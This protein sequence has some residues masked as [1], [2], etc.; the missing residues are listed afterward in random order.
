M[1]TFAWA[2]YI[3]P[4]TDTLIKVH[5]AFTYPA[6]FVQ[7]VGLGFGLF[8]LYTFPDGRFVPRWTKY[9]TLAWA[10][11]CLAWV[12]FP[13]LSI[14]GADP[15][16]MSPLIFAVYFFGWYG[17]GIIAQVYRYLRHSG[18]IQKQQTKWVVSGLAAT[19]VGYGVFLGP[20]M[21]IPS[22]D[23]ATT[24]NMLFE[25]AG[26]T[27]FFIIAMSIPISLALSILRYRLW[28]IDALLNRTIVYSALTAVLA[29]LYLASIG[30]SQRVFVALTGEQSDAAIVLTTLVVASAFT[31]VRTFLQTVVD[32]Y[33]K[34]AHGPAGALAP[35]NTRV[36]AVTQV[37]DARDLTWRMLDEALRS[38][39]AVGGAVYLAPDRQPTHTAGEW[40][41]AVQLSVPIAHEGQ[42]F[43]SLAL[44]ARRDGV[45][46]GPDDREAIESVTAA[47]GRAL[48]LIQVRR[49]AVAR[50]PSQGGMISNA[51]PFV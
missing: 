37:L 51:G 27:V 41:V 42:T 15:Y 47:V 49:D 17:S 3:I 20:R 23:P 2:V 48:W 10:A 25:I 32:R 34:D 5:P 35:F 33:F 13:D 4:A 28:E 38:F 16:N 30:V 50:Q 31:P 18:P 36:T 24:P 14:N 39:G 19:M 6:T 1:G 29:G 9:M 26:Q 8:F 45:E 46:Y 7:A 22:L 40:P 21:L 44:G 12:I 11:W 43:G